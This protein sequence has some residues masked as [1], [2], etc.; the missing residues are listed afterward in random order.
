MRITD[1]MRGAL[2]IKMGIALALFLII[3]AA[4]LPTAIEMTTNGSCTTLGTS[5][6]CAV[7]SPW[8]GTMVDTLWKLIP[9]GGV[10]AVLLYIFR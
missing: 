10:V 7:A 6:T 2:D 9:I 8:K 4:V 3:I 1:K 5:S